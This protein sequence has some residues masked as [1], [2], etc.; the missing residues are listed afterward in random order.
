MIEALIQALSQEI[1][2]SAEEIADT[3]WLALHLSQGETKVYKSVQMLEANPPPIT[4]PSTL[5]NSS[6]P[7]ESSPK[8]EEKK[9]DSEK[10]PSVTPTQADL[11]TLNTSKSTDIPIRVYDAPALRE[12]LSLARALK[13]I[14]QRFPSGRDYLLDEIAT[15][16]KIA[17]EGVWLPVF[18]P[19]PEP[20][21]RIELVIDESISLQI[22]HSTIKELERVLT[23]YG[24]FRDVRIWGLVS[25]EG[26]T[27]KLRRTNSQSLY[28]PKEI[29][30]INR[31]SL[32]LVVSDCVAR[33]WRNGKI[34]QVLDIWAK[35]G[36]LAILQMLP[37]GF[38]S[39][40]ALGDTAEVWLRALN[41]GDVN[42]QLVS[43]PLS[44]WEDIND[45]TGI[46][47]PIFTLEPD[48]LAPWAQML[49]V[50]GETWARGVIFTT[51]VL[52]ESEIENLTEQLTPQER[53]Q[54]FRITTSPVGRKLAGLLAAAPVITLPVVRLIQETMLPNCLQV[55]V[56]EVFL[57][58]LLKPLT[59][60]KPQTNP[61]EVQ[62][63]FVTGVR[64]LLLESVPTD[65]I[66]NVISRVLQEK[67]GL[68]LQE[69]VAYLRIRKQE[70]QEIGYFAT[71]TAEVLRY[72]GGSYAQM[73]EGLEDVDEASVELT[74]IPDFR[75]QVGGSLPPDIPSYIPRES[76]KLLYQALSAGEF[77]YILNSH[78]TGKS[79]LMFRTEKALEQAGIISC[80]LDFLMYEENAV[81]WYY[82]II[83][84]LDGKFQ[85]LPNIRPWI[86]E[87]DY[88]SPVELLREFID[89]ALLEHIQQPLVIFIDEID[90]TLNLPFT[91]DFFALILFC[92]NKRAEN[93]KY[94]K[95]TFALAGRANLTDLIK[96]SK[97]TLFNI[98]TAIDLQGFTLE[99]AKP[100]AVGLRKKAANPIAVLAQ[101]IHW[102]GG[103]PFLTQ[104]LCQ[105]V[106]DS[107]NFIPSGA[108]TTEVAKLVREKIIHNW[109]SQDRHLHLR[110]IERRLLSN[111]QKAGFSLELYRKVRAADGLPCENTTEE[112]ELQLTGLVVKRDG[113]LRVY[114]PI[115]QE[116]FNDK[117]LEEELGKLRPYAESFRAWVASG[118]QDEDRLLRGNALV[119]AMEWSEWSGGKKNLSFEDREFLAASEE[120]E[121]R[122][123]IIAEEKE[124]QL[125]R[126]RKENKSP[127]TPDTLNIVLFGDRCSGKTTYLTSLLTPKHHQKHNIY[128]IN[129]INH[130]AINL[131]SNAQD[132]ITSGL[133]LEAT[134]LQ[135]IDNLLNYHSI[136]TFQSNSLRH[137]F[138]GTILSGLNDS[139]NQTIDINFKEYCG[140]FWESLNIPNRP[141]VIDDYIDELC[142]NN[143]LIFFV[144]ST[145]INAQEYAEIIKRLRQEI[146]Y[147]L[148]NHI[149]ILQK[150]KIAVII[151][152]CEQPQL[153]ANRHNPEKII[154]KFTNIKNSFQQWSNA[155]N[156]PLAYFA[157]S[158]F[159]VM[160]NPPRPNAKYSPGVIDVLANPQ[161]WQPWG[162]MAPIYW[163]STGKFDPR[164]SE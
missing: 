73:V 19:S 144:D 85:L 121:K 92:Y 150:F 24:M 132:I 96:H 153:W 141:S 158:S 75:Y 83:S 71:M 108:E 136:F 11:Y 25:Q 162:L 105:I 103:Q 123:R 14:A 95:L 69:F 128:Q 113:Y 147:R 140:E 134:R 90:R 40:S 104:T 111:E 59:E 80:V 79:S 97:C 15:T 149:Q 32:V 87:R 157:C 110:T 1:D 37:Q 17:D 46:K 66:V 35:N 6:S 65:Y 3:L 55:N 64:E 21:L 56:A 86:N 145:N 130:N 119:E 133:P 31:R 88:L 41:L 62:Y 138:W 5:E 159:G 7:P 57:G 125:E 47:V 118:K 49:A 146:S 54:A 101:I 94:Q 137:D 161:Q 29:I 102:T 23:N 142:Q 67:V 50:R 58:G 109:Q 163:L 12:P 43:K 91:D 52:P 124:A 51:E 115:Y 33:G 68:S 20:W 53:V 36:K 77:C 48:K 13:P 18:C 38:W 61:D 82:G 74:N 117:W 135:G 70:G 120:R 39:R 100:L 34:S 10:N 9:E 2:L 27:V 156:C 98:C 127:T 112:R 42:Q 78:Q 76:D 26:E 81:Q 84:Q 60:I 22:W 106:A 16:K 116:V 107:P 151:S 139:K 89:T 143:G 160:G 152:K 45:E 126:K 99:E 93:P 72:L 30:D 155:W 114:N 4:P 131:I 63:G 148:N 122:E 8:K 154:N 28:S 164:L 44:R 129:A